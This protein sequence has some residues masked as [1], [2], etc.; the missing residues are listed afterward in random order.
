MAQCSTAPLGQASILRVALTALL[1][2]PSACNDTATSFSGTGAGGTATSMPSTGVTSGT[3]ETGGAATATSTGPMLAMVATNVTLTPASNTTCN[4]PAPYNGNASLTWYLFSQGST[5][6]NCSFRLTNNNPDQV[7][8]ALGDG[9]YFAAMNTADYNLAAMCG[10]CVEVTRDGARTVSAMVVD[11]CPVGSNPKCTAG[12]LDLSKSAFLQV[13]SEVDGY[14]GAGNGAA[15]GTVSFRYIPC[16]SVGNVFVR[17][18]EPRNRYW[19]EFLVE[20]HRTPILKFEAFISPNWVPGVRKDYNY[21]NINGGA[22]GLP[23]QVRITDVNGSVIEATLPI[24]S[25][26]ESRFDLG[27]QFPACVP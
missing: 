18:K 5:A 20:N 21:F 25:N 9:Q 16:P 14:V 7:E 17:P 24:M 3:T 1:V 8:F 19:N 23:A 13:G 11:Q 26:G 4:F 27:V 12:H 6:V 22:P 15:V 10:A 2:V